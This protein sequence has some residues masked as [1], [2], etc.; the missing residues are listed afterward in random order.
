MVTKAARAASSETTTGKVSGRIAYWLVGCALLLLMAGT[1]LPSPI[2][3]LYQQ[4]L[5]FSAGVLTLI[6]AGYV[7]GLIPSLLIFGSASDAFGRRR[8]ALAGLAVA[9]VGA[10][11][12]LPAYG[13][14]WLFLART[15]QGVAV[16]ITSGAATA[17]LTELHPNGDRKVAA[18]VATV[19]VAGGGALGPLMGGLLAQYAPSPLVLP[20]LAYVVLFV[21]A[22]VALWAAMPETVTAEEGAG[23]SWKPRRP[24]IPAG[25]RG[26]FAVGASACFAG[27]SVG[28]LFVALVPTYA[29]DL[30][31]IRNLAFQGSVVFAMLGSAAVAQV[32]LSKMPLHRAMISG[33]V[34]LIAGLSALV[35]AVPAQ[36]VWWLLLG[37]ILN[38]VGLGL[39]FKGGLGY[40]GEVAPP[41]NRAEVLSA[42]YVAVYLGVGVPVMGVG[43][44][45]GAFGLFASVAVFA[46][47]ISAL[48]LLVMVS[49]SRV[50]SRP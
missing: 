18:L 32:L 28:G 4:E 34:A 10:L 47:V 12:F 26:P 21:P 23:Q 33:S 44:A 30:L 29:V 46:A 35:V 41:E 14:A 45:A 15:V 36:S 19:A 39:T 25:I 6:F 40:V 22:I 49:A 20:Y 43:F 37:A 42:C 2:Y 38:G 27:W 3:G 13:P 5:G 48:S 11:L 9:V 1:N 24:E 8:V 7:L 16:G 17:A 31:D 50:G